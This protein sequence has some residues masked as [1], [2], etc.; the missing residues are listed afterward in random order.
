MRRFIPRLG[1]NPI[2]IKELR[3]RMRG[4]RAFITLTV[5]LLLI[6][7]LMYAMMQIILSTSRYTN[8][9]SP[10]VGQSMFAALAYLELFMICA[11]TPAVTSGAISSEKE[12]Q[13]YEMLMATQIGRA[14]V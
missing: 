4:P 12:K 7:G 3:S 6:G 11:I 5:I 14:H 10:V 1:V 2:I 13:T 8:I 9:L